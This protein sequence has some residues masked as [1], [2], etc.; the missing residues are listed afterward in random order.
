MD[1]LHVKSEEIAP[2]FLRGYKMATVVTLDS[3]FL[4]GVDQ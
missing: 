1:A 3:R 2:A 4:K